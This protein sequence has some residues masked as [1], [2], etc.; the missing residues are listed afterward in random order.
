MTE[1]ATS[2]TPS[3]ERRLRETVTGY[4]R[5]QVIYTAVKL[6]IP[7]ALLPGPLTPDALARVC[8]ANPQVLPRFLAVLAAEELLAEADSRYALTP[9]GAE[10]C[11]S[12]SGGGL[13]DWVVTVCEEQFF[14]W[15]HALH[16]VRTGHPAFDE[17]YG[18]S[19]WEYLGQN[20]TA[21]DAYEAGMA[22]S[23]RDACEL[24]VQAYDFTGV[25]HIVDVGAGR[26]MLT[27]QL[28]AAQEQVTVTLVDLPDVVERAGKA[29]REAGHGDRWKVAPGSFLEEL[30]SGGDLYVLCR[31]LADW[32][33]DEARRILTNCRRAMSPGARLLIAEGLSRA[34]R[35]AAGARGMLDLHLLL[36]IGGQE[37][38]EGELASLLTECGFEPGLVTHAPHGRVSLVEAVAT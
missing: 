34:E 2:T 33:N 27:M 15:G 12:N 10:L 32:G 7:D 31:V 22:G 25:Q 11:S 24:V 8:G 3:L 29:L 16:T 26:G 6:G 28:L 21:A 20:R 14:A 37:R 17:A 19:F 9:L 30:P 13:A 23:I 4:R 5:S 18:M 36:L 35:G 1:R 38:T